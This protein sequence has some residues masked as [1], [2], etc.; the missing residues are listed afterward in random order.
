MKIKRTNRA[1]TATFWISDPWGEYSSS[2][3]A[4]QVNEGEYPSNS[5]ILGPDGKPLQY[6]QRQKIGFDLSA[7]DKSGW[8]G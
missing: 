7:R 1:N 5:N 3:F 6:E 2:P 4:S 8:I